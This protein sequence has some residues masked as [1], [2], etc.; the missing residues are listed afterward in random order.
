[1]FHI[2]KD[3]LTARGGIDLDR[4]RPVSRLGGI[5]YG[6]TTES[7]GPYRRVRCDFSLMSRSRNSTTE[8]CRS[9]T[10]PALCRSAEA[11]AREDRRQPIEDVVKSVR[12]YG[13]G[14]DGYRWACGLRECKIG[15]AMAFDESS[16][17]LVHASQE[18]APIDDSDRQAAGSL[19]RTASIS[20][21][22]LQGEGSL[23]TAPASF[24]LRCR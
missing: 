23:L 8:V 5:S 15:A 9:V 16:I 21:S 24:R 17:E 19:S 11:R 2:R 14:M 18:A 10:G 6:R 20:R 13:P 22:T 12:L 3:L 1:M 7:Y 4:M